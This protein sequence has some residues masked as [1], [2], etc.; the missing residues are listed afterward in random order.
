MTFDDNNSVPPAATRDESH[1]TQI[2]T[3][4]AQAHRCGM[5]HLASGRICLLPER[6]SGSCDFQHRQNDVEEVVSQA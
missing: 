4:A 1:N 2:N 5:T 6:H 3:A